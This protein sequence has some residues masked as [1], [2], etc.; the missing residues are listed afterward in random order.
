MKTHSRDSV[1]SGE[2]RTADVRVSEAIAGQEGGNGSGLVLPPTTTLAD[3][4]PKEVESF[5]IQMDIDHPCHPKVCVSPSFLPILSSISWSLRAPRTQ[6]FST[7]RGWYLTMIFGTLV[8]NTTFASSAPAGA[9]EP[10]SEKLGLSETVW[11]TT[12]GGGQTYTPC[13]Q[14]NHQCPVFII[15][16]T[17]RPS[18]KFGTR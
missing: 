17:F 8:L 10:I 14:R 7:G 15:P 4:T 1:V 12:I 5:M 2:Y 6:N 9:I 13:Q 18:C 16:L 3:D 11:T